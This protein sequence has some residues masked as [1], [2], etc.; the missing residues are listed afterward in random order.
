MPDINVNFLRGAQSGITTLLQ[1]KANI[2]DGAFYLTED[3]NRLYVGKTVDGVKDLALLNQTVQ[4]VDNMNALFAMSTAWSTAQPNQEAYHVNDWYY[5]TAEN[6]LA[7]WKAK[8]AGVGYEWQQINKNSNTTI[9][10]FSSSV[11]E[12]NENAIVK[13]SIVDSDNNTFGGGGTSGTAQFEIVAGKNDADAPTADISVVDSKIVV[14]GDTYSVSSS[15][16]ENGGANITLTS[17]LGQAGSTVGVVGGDN[18][19]VSN[20]ADG[21]SIQAENWK[22]KTQDASI[23]IENNNGI[24]ELSI[25]G[26][27]NLVYSGATESALGVKVGSGEG[28]LVPLGGN[29]NVYTQTE[30]DQKFQQ[31]DGMTYR[32]TMSKV[33]TGTVSSVYVYAD[34]AIKNTGGDAISFHNGDMFLIN[35]SGVTLPGL[36]DIG[37]GDLV[38]CTG[39]EG[40]DGVITQDTL[41]WTHVPSGNDNQIDTTY[42]FVASSAENKV[43][44]QGSGDGQIATAGALQFV[45]GEKISISSEAADENTSL[46]TTISHATITTTEATEESNVTEVGNSDSDIPTTFNAITGITLSDGHVTETTTTTYKLPKYKSNLS[47]ALTQVQGQADKAVITNSFTTTIGETIKTG[48]S[49]FGISSETLKL[50][51]VDNSTV[52]MELVWGSF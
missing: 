16:R 8:T 9:K 11:E 41:A 52:K 5:C 22:P 10:S 17:A 47:V 13:L 18:V 20:T 34:G 44:L 48:T 3:T 27:D 25:T 29:L 51:V 14:T 37:K 24:I 33:D 30:V 40:A 45:A 31:L 6:V 46:T 26:N 19:T 42:Q 50:S 36:A 43:N 2:Q 7:V 21:I 15:A 4:I 28:T 35:G 39:T 38:I 12:N 1:N 49:N 32:G 23:S